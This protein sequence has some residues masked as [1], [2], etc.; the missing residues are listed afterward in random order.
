MTADLIDIG[1]VKAGPGPDV[2][3]AE[4]L[5]RVI[6]AIEALHA[7]IDVPLSVDTWSV[8]VIWLRNVSINLLM[9]FP[10]AMLAVLAA[11]LGVFF[12]NFLNADNISSVTWGWFFANTFLI[13]GA[14]AAMVAVVMAVVDTAAAVITTRR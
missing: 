14:V 3:E 5:D 13:A 8:I 4:E 10:L 6:P 9:L 2:T 1:G 12:F 11:R 7:R